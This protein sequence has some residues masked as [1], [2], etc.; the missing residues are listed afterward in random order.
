M[1]AI[2]RSFW[3]H[4]IRYRG[5]SVWNR[6]RASTSVANIKWRLVG[7][8]CRGSQSEVMRFSVKATA[9]NHPLSWL[10]VLINSRSIVRKICNHKGT[11][12]ESGIKG[13]AKTS[14]RRRGN[15]GNINRT[16]DHGLTDTCEDGSVEL[17]CPWYDYCRS[18]TYQH[19][20]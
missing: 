6:E 3:P 12:C 15:L 2:A 14:N 17:A 16:D 20:Q 1:A 9:Q 5:D 13:C 19:Q 7:I 8:Y 18:N 10:S 4:F 11:V